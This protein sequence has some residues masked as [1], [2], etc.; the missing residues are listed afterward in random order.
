MN[1]ADILGSDYIYFYALGLFVIWALIFRKWLKKKN[2]SVVKISWAKKLL[3]WGSFILIGLFV[4]FVTFI[5]PTYYGIGTL[6]NFTEIHLIE[7]EIVLFDNHWTHFTDD[8]NASN[9]YSTGH[10]RIHVVD[11]SGNKKYSEMIGSNYSTLVDSNK[12]YIIENSSESSQSEGNKVLN[13]FR[14]HL[15]TKERELI[16]E[17]GGIIEVN[18]ENVKVYDIEVLINII[19]TSEK[20]DEFIYDFEHDEFV[21][22]DGTN[23]QDHYVLDSDNGFRFKYDAA[24]SNKKELTFNNVSCEQTFLFGEIFKSFELADSNY[25]LLTS[26]ETM[27]QTNIVYSMVSQSGALLWEKKL[28]YFEKIVDDSGFEKID[29]VLQNDTLIYLT[30][31]S[32]LFALDI[33]TAECEWWLKG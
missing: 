12:V 5:N 28:A 7:D 1:V 26:Y 10:L 3:M 14:Y 30:I 19:V 32:Y 8:D 6:D 13:V 4:F 27:K 2:G 31:E 21:Q 24:S 9:S 20:G 15:D 11:S 16:V 17:N 23:F 33:R 29:L 22:F 18:G 25:A